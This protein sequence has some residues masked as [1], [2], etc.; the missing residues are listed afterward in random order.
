MLLEATNKSIKYRLRDG[1]EVL[2]KPG[3]PIEVPDDAA[4]YLLDKAPGRVQIASSHSQIAHEPVQGL[5]PLY[6]E[7]ES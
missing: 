1:R 3:L 5:S 7:S 6:W 4:R 2:L